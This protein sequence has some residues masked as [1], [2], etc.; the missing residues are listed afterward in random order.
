MAKKNVAK[1]ITFTYEGKEYTLEYNRR[2]VKNIM[3]R[4]GFSLNE[5]DSKPLTMLPLLFWGAFQAHHKGITQD[6][7]DKMLEHFTN[8]DVLF[9]KLSEMYVEPASVLF[10]EPEE[11]EGNVSWDPSW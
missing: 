5:V 11:D 7:T 10:D 1:T 9:E 8:K 4:R 6:I 2:V 3:E